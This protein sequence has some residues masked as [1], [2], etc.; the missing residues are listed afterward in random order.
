MSAD[1]LVAQPLLNLCAGWCIDLRADAVRCEGVE[2]LLVV[3][4]HAFPRSQPRVV[5]CRTGAGANWPHIDSDGVLCL[6]SSKLASDPGD[7]VMQHLQWAHQLLNFSEIDCRSEF[8]R[9]FVAYWGNRCVLKNDRPSVVSLLNPD[10]GAREIFFYADTSSR[11]IVAADS[12]DELRDWLGNRGKKTIDKNILRT[13]LIDLPRPWTPDEYPKIGRDVLNYVPA[14]ASGEVALIPGQH[15]PILF[16]V[17]TSTGVVFVTTMLQSATPYNLSKG[18]RTLDRV[19]LKRIVDSF[20]SHPVQL[21]PVARAD[22][23]WVHGRDRDTTFPVL[24]SKT[25]VILGC[26]S[27]GAAIARLLAQSGIGNFVL[28]D[29]DELTTSN[30]S[31]HILGMPYVGKYKAQ[32]VEA[33]LQKDFPHIQRTKSYVRRFEALTLSDLAYISN[34]DLIISAGI[35]FEGDA[36]LDTWRRALPMPPAHLCTWAEAFAIVGHAVVLYGNESLLT[37]FDDNERPSFRLTEWSD[38]SSA[39]MVEAGCGN[40]FQPHGAVDLQSTVTLAASL[41]VDVLLDK[42]PSSCR[43]T[44]QGNLADVALKGGISATNFKESHVLKEVPWS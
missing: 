41:A 6:K 33:M 11:L 27:L 12:S 39:L 8:E 4:D 43:R 44:W 20:S 19:P 5:V 37:G 40:V 24:R 42:V 3:V 31:R 28:I 36:N 23:Y 35:D 17:P 13:W 32:A 2:R 10:G 9:E 34:A 38:A 18:F 22:G 29:P 1:E 25:V 14:Q 26:G 15:N 7:R 16:R 21:L 30:V